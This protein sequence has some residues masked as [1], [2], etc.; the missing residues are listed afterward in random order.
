MVDS[1]DKSPVSYALYK[2]GNRHKQGL[3][4]ELVSGYSI[5]DSTSS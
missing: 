1:D 5:V 2:L 3:T 4:I